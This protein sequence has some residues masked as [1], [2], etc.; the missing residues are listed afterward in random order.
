M[1]KIIFISIALLTLSTPNIASAQS[2]NNRITDDE[3]SVVMAAMCD[4]PDDFTESQI[5]SAIASESDKTISEERLEV[6]KSFAF[7]MQMM[8]SSDVSALCQS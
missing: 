7:L 8:P 6:L 2:S 5:E 4:V 3:M 1:K